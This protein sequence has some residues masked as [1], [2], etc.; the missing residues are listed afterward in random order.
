MAAISLTSTARVRVRVTL[1][2]AVYR[3]SVRLG[4]KPL[5]THDTVI[6]FSNWTLAVLHSLWRE[7]ESV[8]Y[9]CCWSSPSQSF[10]GQIPTGLMTTYYFLRFEA[11]PTWR[12]RSPYLYPPGI[13]WLC[14]TPKHWISFSTSPTTRRATVE[15]FD[16]GSTQENPDFYE[17]ITCPDGPTTEHYL[18]Q[19]VCCI[20]RIRC[21]GK[22]YRTVIWQWPIPSPPVVMQTCVNS[23]ATVR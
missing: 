22:A 19:L 6:L 11:P 10:S 23:T 7:D 4:D 3:Q 13:W 14:C 21:H 12:V 17:W 5:E 18:E 2:W 15:V 16:P 9:N 20:L 8:I 1:R